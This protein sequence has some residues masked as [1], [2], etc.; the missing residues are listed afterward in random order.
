M[1]K[2]LV[3]LYII[4]GAILMSCDPDATDFLEVNQSEITDFYNE[5]SGESEPFA[6]DTYTYKAEPRTGSTFAWEVKGIEA[7]IMQNSEFPFIAEI[8]FGNS[9][10]DLDVAVVVTETTEW[11]ESKMFTDSVNIIGFCPLDLD[12]FVGTYTEYLDDDPGS[13]STVTIERN[14]DDERFGL[15]I[16]SFGFGAWSGQT[17]GSLKISLDNCDNSVNVLTQVVEG[18]ED[19]NGSGPVSVGL[20]D[21]VKGTFD[22]DTKEISFIG[23]VTV[24]DGPIGEVKFSYFKQ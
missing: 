11:G 9:S 21:N 8:T 4:M 7:S 5:I 6:T 13:E 22:P 14:P 24:A 18:I 15:I 2:N 17:E 19:F 23:E 10:I 16:R 1:K 20:N 3:Y 12:Q